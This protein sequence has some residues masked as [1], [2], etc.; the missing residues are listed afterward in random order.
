MPMKC[1]VCQHPRRKEIE[2]AITEGMLSLRHIVAQ[3]G[4]SLG[5]LRR[6]RDKCMKEAVAAA[7]IAQAEEKIESGLT[8]MEQLKNA[9]EQT[10]GIVDTSLEDGKDLKLALAGLAE[11]RKHLELMAKLTGELDTRSQVNIGLKIDFSALTDQQLLRLADGEDP[12][13]VLG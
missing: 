3:C 11:I 12:H 4:T 10:Q 5:S 1:T 2:D 9:L 8:T 13:A 6:H 7:R